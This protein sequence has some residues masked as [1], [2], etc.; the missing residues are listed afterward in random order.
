MTRGSGTRSRT[1]YFEE[2]GSGPPLLLVHGLMI[3]G[4]MFA[5]VRDRFAEHHRV[6]IPDLRGYG[7][8]R[9]LPPPYTAA[10]LAADLAD[11]LNSLGIG[12]CDVL[13]YSH[14]G[15]IAQQF[16]LDH[17]T[18]VGG[19]VLACTY[20]FNMATFQEKIEGH[21]M[22]VLVRLLGPRRLARLA[23]AGGAREMMGDRSAWLV[24]LM[25]GQDRRLMVEAF[26]QAMAFDSRARLG[27]I[28]A[29]TLV[30]AAGHDRAVPAHHTDQLASSI[31]GARKVVVEEAGHA[32]IWTH[33][34]ELVRLTEQFLREGS[35]VR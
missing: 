6:L 32:L 9:D 29:R 7:R 33:P 25:A 20:A 21:L 28:K 5:G 35:F 22:P 12:Q 24:D 1:L 30:I 23:M 15:A 8:S 31:P 13:G 17:P 10:R 11:L 26:R 18:H 34:D 14:G 4:G 3:P 19:L 27:E 16:A 2:R